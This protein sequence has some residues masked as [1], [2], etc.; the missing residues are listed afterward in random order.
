[1]LRAESS[2]QVW[3]QFQQTGQNIRF[4]TPWPFQILTIAWITHLFG[5]E[6]YYSTHEE[7]LERLPQISLKIN[8]PEIFV[9]DQLISNQITAQLHYSDATSIKWQQRDRMVPKQIGSR[10]LIFNLNEEYWQ[11]FEAKWESGGACTA[12]LSTHSPT[13]CLPLTGLQQVSPPIGQTPR[14]ISIAK[15][16]YNID[17]ESYQFTKDKKTFMYSDASGQTKHY[18]CLK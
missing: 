18:L 2:L 17:F 8:D 12:V 4:S 11:A 6:F 10:E 3:E 15:D 1:M 13:A 5:S 7:K 9:E 14:I 16:S